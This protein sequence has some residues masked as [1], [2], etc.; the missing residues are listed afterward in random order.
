[1]L[2][3]ARGEALAPLGLA[4]GFAGRSV[5]EVMTGMLD[6][7]LLVV[8]VARSRERRAGGR[9]PSLGM[10]AACGRG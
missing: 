2:G 6:L 7:T 4:L 1:M 10:G 9:R 8:R 5:P 3:C